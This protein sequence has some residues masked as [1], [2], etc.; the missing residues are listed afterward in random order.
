MNKHVL[1]FR[2]P[3]PGMEVSADAV[4]NALPS[5]I[6]VVAADLS[7]LHV[8]NAAEQFFQSSAQ[9]LQKA[10]LDALL[11]A[12]SPL[13]SLIRQ[14]RATN[15]TVA[16][17]HITLSNPRVGHHVVNVQAAPVPELPDVV[18]ISFQERSVA[19][20]ID[21]Q[22]THRG[23]A[24]SMSA[25]AAMLA[26]EVKNPL[27]G[28]RGAA[29][30]LEQGVRDEDQPLTRLI[31]EETDRVC[32][33]VNRMEAFSASG[34]LERSPVNIH[35]V[36]G[37]VRA[38][39][40]N[41][42]GRHVRFVDHYDPSLPPVFGNKD[43]LIQVFLNLVKNAAEAAPV[44]EGEVTITSAYWHGV[45]FA[46]AGSQ[47]RVELPLMISVQDNGAGI[48][49]DLKPHLFE[50]FVTSKPKGSGLGLAL[51]AKIIGDHGGVIEF[52]SEPRRTVF[53]VMLPM[54]PDRDS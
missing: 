24:R 40:E 10:R 46:V 5:V 14:A 4:L 23:A 6:L 43:Q 45:R 29:Q 54:Y 50:P 26:H 27:A 39:A 35:E 9:H 21:H 15:S 20:K 34:P 3:T 51:V 53:R 18:V 38:L 47:S 49:E 31:R 7:I 2:R 16:E 42:F 36:L 37:R 22:L 41:S 19:A 8:N 25:M 33:I 30:L 32:A 44:D 13:F 17:Y 1:K 11:P 52:E 48:P 28:I 12:D